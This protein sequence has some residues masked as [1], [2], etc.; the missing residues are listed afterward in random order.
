[1]QHRTVRAF[2]AVACSGAALLL[3]APAAAITLDDNGDISLGVRTYVNARIGTQD[4]DQAVTYV[5]DANGDPVLNSD[6]YRIP[7]TR[8]QTF[9]P[10]EGAHLRQNRFFIEAELKHSLDRLV[11]KGIGPFWLVNE[12]PFRVRGLKYGL[13]YRGEYDGI[14]DWGPHEYR[15]AWTADQFIASQGDNLPVNPSNPGV[16]PGDPICSTFPSDDR[17]RRIVDVPKGRRDLRDDAVHRSRLYQAYFEADI[18]SSLWFRFGRQIVAWGETDSF[19]LLDNINP[20]DNSF[21]GFLIPLDERRVPLDMLRLQYRIGEIGP[22]YEIFVEAYGAI[23]DRVGYAP[24]TPKGSPWALPNVGEPSALSL[25]Y[26]DSPDR[27]FDDMRGGARLVFNGWDATFSLAHYYTYLDRPALQV[28]TNPGGGFP[29]RTWPDG[30]STHYM[31]T[32]QKTQITGGTVT[33]PVPMNLARMMRLSGQPIVRS[34]FAY[35]EDEARYRQSEIDPFV[36]YRSP[37]RPTEGTR[38][39]GDSVNFVFGLDLNQFIRP[40]NPRQSFFIS[41]Q[42]FYKHLLGYADDAEIPYG[43]FKVRERE[44]LPVPQFFTQAVGLEST[45]ATEP[46]FVR[47]PEN[48]FLQT[49][50]ISTSY[51]SSKVNPQ[52]LMVYDW[53]GAFV[54]QPGVTLVRDPFRVVLDYTF[55]TAGTLKGG[56]GVSLLRDRD[57]VQIRFEYVL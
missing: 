56:S 45:Y 5:T 18:G 21:G 7:A 1:M 32:P 20:I 48:Q 36:V 25:N 9:P 37:G 43:R 46:V 57:N 54:L 51:M 11:K 6:G 28:A 12:L 26:I 53:G 30:Y 27:N 40:L 47:E 22:L 19:R 39:T 42:F 34:E 23:D 2:V 13:T 3:S 17:C 31:Q 10:S 8:S 4:T 50:L 15:N 35:F 16:L 33:F 55:I 44:V 24:G 49:L 29:T 41:T 14:Y 38:R 52:L